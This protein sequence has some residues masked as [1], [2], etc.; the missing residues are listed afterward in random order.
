MILKSPLSSNPPDIDPTLTRYRPDTTTLYHRMIYRVTTRY[1]G[2]IYGGER[3]IFLFSQKIKNTTP[4]YY[5]G[6]N[7][8]ICY[9]VGSSKYYSHESQ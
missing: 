2:S 7:S 8:L 9:L 6:Q 5:F 3:Q 1:S 4:G